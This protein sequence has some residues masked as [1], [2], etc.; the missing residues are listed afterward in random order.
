LYSC[1]ISTV[2]ELSELGNWGTASWEPN[3]LA[4]FLLRIL[5]HGLSQV[6]SQWLVDQPPLGHKEPRP[7]MQRLQWCPACRG[8]LTDPLRLTSRHV[9]EECMAVE[10]CRIRVGIRAFL[11]SCRQ[12]GWSQASAYRLYLTGKNEQDIKVSKKDYLLRGASLAVL[13]DSWLS[14]WE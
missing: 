13:T 8:M 14:T 9:L 12:A 5:G 2:Q 10:A 6:L 4:C 11:S 7:N 3:L 1:H